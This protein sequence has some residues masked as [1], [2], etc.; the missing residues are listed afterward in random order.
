MIGDH[1][2][3]E[4]EFPYYRIYDEA[5]NNVG[6]NRKDLER[7]LKENYSKEDFKNIPIDPI[8]HALNIFKTG[9]YNSGWKG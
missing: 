3:Y 2:P 6:L 5:I 7:F 1:D 8:I 9:K 4:G